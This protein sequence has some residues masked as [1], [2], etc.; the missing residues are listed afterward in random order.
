MDKNILNKIAKRKEEVYD[1]YY[2]NI[3]DMI[4][5]E[6]LNQNMTQEALAKGICSNT[7][8][9]KMENNK[10]AGTN[11]HIYLLM[12]R[13]GKEKDKILMPDKMIE[14]LSRALLYFYSKDI[15][16]YEKLYGELV[17]YEYG[18]LIYVIRLGFYI[19]KDDHEAAGDIYNNMYRY[20]NS[21]DDY[22]FYVFLIFGCFYLVSIHDYQSAKGILDSM[23]DRL[24]N[25]QM[26]YALYHHLQFVIYGELHLFSMAKDG[27][28]VARDIYLSCC[29][30]PRLVEIMIL[31]HKFQAYEKDTNYVLPV[32]IERCEPRNQDF[33]I[34]LIIAVLA[35]KKNIN[36]LDLLEPT[37]E[38]HLA[39]LLVQA[40]YF[41]SEGNKEEYQEVK[42]LISDRQ[43]SIDTPIDYLE[44]LS[45]YEGDDS[46]MLKEYLI[47][48]VL[49]YV[50]AHQNLY[51]HR[52]V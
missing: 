46:S 14:Q 10:L 22:G 40:I 42:K 44:L 18:I 26:L 1:F 49:P 11:E 45:L 34:I 32:M 28:M 35:S 30:Y 24:A 19:L 41:G 27:L 50:E 8:I 31:D 5:R 9:S 36:I 48:Y 25:D 7:Y 47:T 20:F 15:E 13:V 39:G 51:F 23:K 33:N 37:G 16:S 3:G 43:A 4:R 12:E 52:K 29:N 21:L 17:Q 38:T 6:R 2:R